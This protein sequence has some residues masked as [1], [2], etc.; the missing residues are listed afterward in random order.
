MLHLL[1]V[2]DKHAAELIH[3]KKSGKAFKIKK[4]PFPAKSI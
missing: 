1:E 3:V 4:K 2:T